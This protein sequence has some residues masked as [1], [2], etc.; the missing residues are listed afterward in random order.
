MAVLRLAL[1][2]TFEARLDS[3]SAVT[4]P[5]KKSEALLA[6]LALQPGR[7]IARDKLAALLWGDASDE[8]ARHSLRQALVTLRQALPRAAAAC[9]V[10]EGDNVGVSPT[11]VEVDVTRFEALAT[12]ASPEALERAAALY[13]GDLLEGMSVAEPP[14]EEWLRA[15][16]E[17]LREL[18]IESLAKLLAHHARTDAV[19]HAVQTAIRLLGLEPGQEAVH[20]TLMRL[21]ARQHRRGAPRRRGRRRQDA[22][23]GSADRRGD[24]RGGPGL[25]RPRPRK[26]GSPAARPLGGRVA[27]R[28]R[29]SRP[30][31]GSRCP[32]A[33][34]ACAPLSGVGAG[35]ARAHR[36]RRLRPSLRGD[37]ACR[38]ARVGGAAA[39]RARRSPLGGRD[40]PQTARVPGAEDRRVAD[41]RRRNAARGGDGGFADAA[42]DRRPARPSAALLLPDPAAAVP[43]RDAHAGASAGQH[44]DRGGARASARGTDLAGERG[45]PIHGPRDGARASGTRGGRSAGGNLHAP[46]RPRGHRG[47]A[48]S[49]QRSGTASGRRGERHRSRMRLRAAGARGRVARHGDR[50]RRRRAGRAPHPARRGRTP[51]LHARA[52]AGG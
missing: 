20:R 47:T 50:R 48:G 19:E 6:Y 31:R 25:A 7:M 4:F 42:T 51:R 38:P 35:G 49:A 3:G 13:R 17:R 15:E 24:E 43:S 27:R 34:R 18:A 9:L 28:P 21:Y 23:G 52:D 44:E 46:A 1:L 16:R 30:D 33:A 10:E 11:A 12:A 5:R 41:P 37:G 45:Q 8:R 14:F 39:H 32:V 26:R 29:R 40:E 22:A 36:G 2:G